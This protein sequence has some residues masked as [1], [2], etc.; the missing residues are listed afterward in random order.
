[1]FKRN[2]PLTAN[3]LPVFVFFGMVL[4]SGILEVTANGYVQ[5]ILMYVLA[6]TILAISLNLVR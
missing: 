5:R 3:L 1:M 6:N 2:S 4:L